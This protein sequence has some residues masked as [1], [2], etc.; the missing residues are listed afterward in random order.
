MPGTVS[1]VQYAQKER[2]P[3]R[4][5]TSFDIARQRDVSLLLVSFQLIRSWGDEPR[6]KNILTSRRHPSTGFEIINS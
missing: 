1:H 3:D 4:N 2:L 6:K 5:H